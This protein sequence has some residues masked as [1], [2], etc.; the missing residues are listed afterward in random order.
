MNDSFERQWKNWRQQTPPFESYRF[1]SRSAPTYD[2]ECAL[3]HVRT[4]VDSI[5]RGLNEAR[6]WPFRAKIEQEIGNLSR[7]RLELSAIGVDEARHLALNS[8]I[9]STQELLRSLSGRVNAAQDRTKR[10]PALTQHTP[11]EQVAAVLIDLLEGRVARE[12][13]AEWASA[14]VRRHEP[15]DLTKRMWSAVER[16]AGADSPTT[17]RIYLYG[18][19]DFETWLRDLL[20]ESD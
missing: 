8:W 15:P 13:V 3:D 17:D 4:S 7:I 14:Y 11:A 18:E 5:V 6:E 16:M 19:N 12:D 10:F 1:G 20:I 9:H 2:I